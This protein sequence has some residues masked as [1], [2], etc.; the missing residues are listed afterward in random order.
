MSACLAFNGALTAMLPGIACAVRLT[1]HSAVSDHIGLEHICTDGHTAW[2]CQWHQAITHKGGS[3]T[4]SRSASGQSAEHDRVHLDQSGCWASYTSTGSSPVRDHV[5]PQA[6]QQC[7]NEALLCLV[8]LLGR[9]ANADSCPVEDDVREQVSEPLHLQQF[10]CL[11]KPLALLTY[12]D[13]A[14]TDVRTRN[15]RP[16]NRQS[17][18]RP[19]IQ[20]S[21]QRP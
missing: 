14:K 17:N 6:D 11:A 19:P 1:K 2:D 7:H 4:R 18:R 12:V 5:W 3:C 15:T 21:P 13:G 10:P 8:R 16:R 9:V 20:T